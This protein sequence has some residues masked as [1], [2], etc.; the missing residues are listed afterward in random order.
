MGRLPNK[1]KQNP[2]LIQ[3]E[4]SDGRASLWLEYYLGRS[5]TPLYDDDG[6]P[7]L[8]ESG[9]MKGKP[10]YR[11]KHLR[12]KE[13]IN[14]YVWLHPRTAQERQQNKNTLRL[15]EKLRFEKEQ[16]MLED[17]KGYRLKREKESNFIRYFQQHCDNE[18]F[19]LPVRKSYKYSL[20]RFKE[21]LSLTPRYSKYVTIMPMDAVTPD[22]VLGFTNYLRKKCSGEGPRKNYH[23]FKKVLANAVEGELIK[24][25]PCKGIRIVYDTNVVLK[26]ILTPKEINRLAT[27]RYDGEHREVQRAF[28]FCCFTGLRYCDV[29]ALKFAN[30]DYESMVMRFNQKKSAGRSAHAAVVTPL[31]NELLRLI[32]NP[33]EENNPKELIFNLPHTGTA[34]KHLA[35]WVRLAGIKKSITWHC[36]RHSFA[37]NLLNAG[38][39]IKTVSS[40]LG[41]A[42]IKMTEK[43]L[44]VIDQ[45]K[46]KAINKLGKVAFEIDEE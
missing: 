11:V 6:N 27:F 33:K 8:Y 26:E 22:L 43:Y 39:D 42:S 46:Q 25:N 9:A 32:G 18:A 19:T 14:L 44:H 7:V 5:E 4:M 31:N 45:R 15:A 3:R 23:W 17:R 21:Y 13:A 12:R 30:V 40:L 34:R 20:I 24:R 35:R 16:E 37:V 36:S 29:S 41:H 2:K 1:L 10:K 28:I 38:T